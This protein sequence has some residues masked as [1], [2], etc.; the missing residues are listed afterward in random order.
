MDSL[1][2][3]LYVNCP[4]SLLK[5]GYLDLVLRYKINPEIGIDGVCLDTYS[6]EDFRDIARVL[7]SANLKVTLHAPFMDL[8]LGSPEPEIRKASRKRLEQF[9]YLIP[10]LRPKVAVFHSGWDEK[11]YWGMREQWLKDSVDFWKWISRSLR[12]EGVWMNIENVF[13]KTPQELSTLIQSI[14]EDNIGICLDVGHLSAFSR[15]PLR[16]WVLSLSPLIRQLHL[17]DNDGSQDHHRALGAG[18]INFKELF[19]L[20]KIHK[21]DIKAITLE[22]HREEDLWP[23]LQYLSRLKY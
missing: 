7:R 13:E 18:K 1:K 16:E 17:H 23:S 3:I 15:V 14:G 19:N 12:K 22:P 9:I 20:I 5:E 8:S 11:R 21:I 4:F 6:I 10:I 2:E